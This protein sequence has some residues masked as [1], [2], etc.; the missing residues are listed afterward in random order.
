MYQR[1]ELFSSLQPEDISSTLSACTLPDKEE[2]TE[3]EAD[4]FQECRALIE[5]GKNYKQA[6]AHFRRIDRKNQH[7]TV[8]GEADQPESLLDISELLALAS[9]QCEQRITLKEAALILDSCGLP[10]IEQY[11][12]EQGDRFL[13][14]C[15]LILKQNKSYEEVAAHFGGENTSSS[16][17][18]SQLQ[19]IVAKFSG[20]A[21]T[22][23]SELL[24]LASRI[25]K[26]QV[27]ATDIDIDQ[28]MRRLYLI[29]VSQKAAKQ[30]DKNDTIFAEIE[31]RVLDQIEGKS[32][33]RSL[34][35]IWDRQMNSL[36]PSSPKLMS[37]PEESDN[38]TTAS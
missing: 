5:Q 18:Q 3:S 11:T 15:D 25:A 8:Q 21:T 7:F 2:Y 34:Q 23:E 13:E 9:T 37:L 20:S 30:R 12:S 1:T 35:A 28:L 29:E 38:G 14:A 22:A 27:D 33:V 36:P 16:D 19:Q 4:R 24:E 31:Q 32:P 26:K 10:D 17:L 6:A